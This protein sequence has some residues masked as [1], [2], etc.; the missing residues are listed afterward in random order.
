[1][2]RGERGDKNLG[3]IN[4]RDRRKCYKTKVKKVKAVGNSFAGSGRVRETKSFLNGKPQDGLCPSEGNRW[5]R[6][7]GSQAIHTDSKL[8]Q[9]TMSFV[10]MQ[11]ALRVAHDRVLF[12]ERSGE[13]L[14][15]A[16]LSGKAAEP[17]GNQV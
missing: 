1:M 15:I 10:L 7:E 5:P 17:K 6:T 8:K 16:R 4:A 2:Q 13:L 9:M 11:R 3:I 14:V 12:V